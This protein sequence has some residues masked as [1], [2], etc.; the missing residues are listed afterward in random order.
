MGQF[1]GYTVISGLL[2]PTPTHP[3]KIA[4]ETVFLD[5]QISTPF[6]PVS[7]PWSAQRPIPHG[8]KK[9]KRIPGL[10]GRPRRECSATSSGRRRADSLLAWSRAVTSA[11]TPAARRGTHNDG[12]TARTDAGQKC[13]A[14]TGAQDGPHGCGGNVRGASPHGQ[15]IN[16]MG[17]RGEGGGRVRTP[18]H[19]SAKKKRWRF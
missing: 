19:P 11:R 5:F 18:P 2:G 13:A 17:G 12:G 6:E 7:G 3:P 4:K 8:S 15:A 14:N 16:E 1:R 10:M 9:K